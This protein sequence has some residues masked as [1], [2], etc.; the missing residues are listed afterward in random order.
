MSNHSTEQHRFE[1]FKHFVEIVSAWFLFLLLV[2]LNN[3]TIFLSTRQ[4]LQVNSPETLVF[5]F[6]LP[7]LCGVA[8]PGFINTVPGFPA[9]HSWPWLVW[10]SP[11]TLSQPSC[12]AVQVDNDWLLTTHDC[13]R[14][15]PNNFITTSTGIWDSCSPNALIN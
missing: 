11:S 6:T 12:A 1:N 14:K 9:Y 4:L 13:A 15:F 7:D 2:H 5:S 3:I 10:L 8:Y